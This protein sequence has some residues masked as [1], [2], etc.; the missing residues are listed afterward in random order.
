MASMNSLK[1]LTIFF[2][3]ACPLCLAEI[4]FLKSRNQADLLGFVDINSSNY[5]SQQVGV[6]CSEALSKMYGQVEGEVPINGVAVFA[7]AYRRADLKILTWIFT[8]A[9]LMPLLKP[10][11]WFF[12]RYRHGISSLVG[13]W[14]LRFVQKRYPTSPD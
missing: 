7:E 1:R 14:L 11:Y 8:R 5:D 12:A 6:S 3:G 9:W 13:P 4:T 10:S 2:D